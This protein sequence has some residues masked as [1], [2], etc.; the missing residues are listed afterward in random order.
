[1][2]LQCV[3]GH[4]FSGSSCGCFHADV[5]ARRR[6]AELLRQHSDKAAAEASDAARLCA[7]EALAGSREQS[8]GRLG[9]D[10]CRLNT[11][12][13]RGVPSQVSWAQRIFSQSHILQNLSC[14]THM[15]KLQHM[16]SCMRVDPLANCDDF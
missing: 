9:L 10:T 7:Q 15:S 8:A 12:V 4:A 11:T 13:D 5:Q 6:A 1:M 14:Q 16:M 2:L 3:Y